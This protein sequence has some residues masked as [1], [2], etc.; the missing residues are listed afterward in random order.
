M[1]NSYN[2]P[3][4]NE[5]KIRKRDKNCVYCH[6]KLKPYTRDKGTNKATIEHMNNDGPYDKEWNIAICCNS[7]NSRKGSMKLFDWFESPYCK[8]NNINKETVAPVIKGWLNSSS[9]NA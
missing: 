7:C 4:K 6:V 2:I 9:Q 3:D 1:A 5:Q 8:K